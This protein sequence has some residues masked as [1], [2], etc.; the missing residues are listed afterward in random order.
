MEKLL[1]V[2]SSGVMFIGKLKEKTME[3]YILQDV[4]VVNILMK[5]D[6]T[7]L[8]MLRPFFC[9]SMIVPNGVII[10]EPNDELVDIYIKEMTRIKSGLHIPRIDVNINERDLDNKKKVS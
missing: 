5:Q 2:M 8:M 7:G 1:G 10:F 3:G 9:K 4:A 6:G